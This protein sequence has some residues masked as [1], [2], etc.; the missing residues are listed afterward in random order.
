MLVY[1]NMSLSGRVRNVYAETSSRAIIPN[2][3]SFLHPYGTCDIY[4]SHA[5]VNCHP[6]RG[7][8]LE[9]GG[10]IE[11][12]IWIYISAFAPRMPQ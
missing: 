1:T 3:D 7:R 11:Y 8:K 9:I 12:L 6:C 10:H 2:E 4:Q 5:I